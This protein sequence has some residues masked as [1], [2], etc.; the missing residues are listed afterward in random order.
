[1]NRTETTGNLGRNWVLSAHCLAKHDRTIRGTTRIPDVHRADH[2]PPTRE[3]SLLTQT[4]CGLVI[5]EHEEWLCKQVD[6][7]RLSW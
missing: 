5:H 1:M 3:T 4:R 7:W 6:G 2:I